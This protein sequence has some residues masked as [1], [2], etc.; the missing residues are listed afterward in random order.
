MGNFEETTQ[1]IGEIRQ[2]LQS[3][4]NEKQSLLDPEV[5]VASQKLDDALNT[6]ESTLKES[7]K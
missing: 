5:L 2:L 1:T 4:I 3:L 6:Y 7:G